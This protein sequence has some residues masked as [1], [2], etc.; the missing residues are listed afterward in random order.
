MI[1][2][3]LPLQNHYTASGGKS[4]AS[5]GIALHECYVSFSS[6]NDV[7]D[8]VCII[9]QLLFPIRVERGQMQT[10]GRS[11][12]GLCCMGLNCPLRVLYPE[13]APGFLQAV[14]PYLVA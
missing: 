4:T 14:K 13:D 6:V 10:N 3:F 1:S 8:F 7:H 2:N 12:L 5:G 9:T 11:V